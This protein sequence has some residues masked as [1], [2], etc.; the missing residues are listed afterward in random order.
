MT[1]SLLDRDVAVDLGT[2]AVRVHRRGA[3]RTIDEPALLARHRA[4]GRPV[5]FGHDALRIVGRNPAP[6]DVTR[7]IV[8]GTVADV[9]GC[10]Q[11]LRLV[12]DRALARRRLFARRPGVLVAVPAATTGLERRAVQH[13][14]EAAG[15]RPPVVVMEAP[16]AA[17]IGAGLPV[18]EAYGSMIVDVGRGI[19]EA[20][21]VCLGAP[22]TSA[23]TRVGGAR[24]DRVI[25]DCLR[26]RYDVAVGEVTAEHTKIALRAAC[27]ERRQTL[28]VR[29][30]DVDTG[31][32][33]TVRVDVADLV[34]ALRDPIEAIV[35]T[36]RNA[37]DGAPPTLAADVMEEGIFLT[38]GGA[39][40]VGLAERLSDATGITVTTAAD[41]RAAVINGARQCLDVTHRLGG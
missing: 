40:L 18:E 3:A 24:V 27:D 16:L 38:G 7:P 30:V 37:L 17:A 41:P 10:E 31:L 9:V 1:L 20:A 4:T 13:A 12:F 34:D 21:V 6:I 22:I 14:V 5:A 11:L 26:D 28:D 36:V 8:D 35:T 2:S 15:A 19:T 29:G 33:R 32:P 39:L 23:S 25:A